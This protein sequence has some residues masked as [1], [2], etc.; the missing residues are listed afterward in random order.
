[1]RFYLKAKGLIFFGCVADREYVVVVYATFGRTEDDM[2]GID[3][4]RFFFTIRTYNSDGVA[5]GDIRIRAV[6]EANRVGVRRRVINDIIVFARTYNLLR[7]AIGNDI[8]VIFFYV[9]NSVSSGRGPCSVG[10]IPN[11]TVYGFTVV[12]YVFSSVYNFTFFKAVNGKGAVD[13]VI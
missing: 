11:V 12:G 5:G 1:M 7:S 6:G 4:F 13:G 8:N 9:I 10:L 3:I 2:S